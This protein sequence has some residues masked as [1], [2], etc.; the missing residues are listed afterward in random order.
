M[1]ET[2]FELSRA[3]N[4]VVWGAPMLILLIGTGIYLSVRLHFLQ[5]LRI[6]EW[7]RETFGAL[8]G[9]RKKFSNGISPFRAVSSALASSIGT[10]NIIGVA[11][12]IAAGGAGAVFWIWV[13]AFF[14][15]ATKYTE[16]VLA[17]KFRMRGEKGYYGGPMYYIEKGLGRSWKPL[18]C[19]FAFSASL[20][21]LGM[22]GM[23]QSNAIASVIC[24]GSGIPVWCVGA[25][26][27]MIC[28]AAVSGGIS[29]VSAFAEKIVPVMSVL[30]VLGGIAV[31]F[32]SPSGALSAIKSIFV[33]AFAP[34]A[35]YGAAAGE[36][37]RRAVRFGTAR[38][39]FSNEA[40]LGSAPI[41]HSAADAKSPVAQ[42]YWGIFE[43]F[44][45]T[46]VICSVTAITILSAGLYTEGIDAAELVI[47]SFSKFFGE[48]GGVFVG[49]AT[50]L[51]SLTTILGW[52]Y[53]GEQCADYLAGGR[54]KIIPIYRALFVCAVFFGALFPVKSV[55]EIA[56]TFNGIMMLPNL[57]AVLLLSGYAIKETADERKSP[58]RRTEP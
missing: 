54:G 13:S 27:A 6:R 16:I 49:T 46:I 4:R 43:V 20:A 28:I 55:W 34:S 57:I 40:G 9:G 11:T 42:G 30:Y 21:C 12:A 15:M 36:M 14:G 18:A 41:V 47:A 24:C 56:D 53:Y 23:N 50:V 2:L 44:V 51:F 7:T 25:A 58:A 31:I 10:G 26:L 29:R 35:V 52:S 5:I 1:Q 19:V 38:G 3:V 45:D 17:V 8:F 32:I 22:G 33:S 48:L 39:V 37:V